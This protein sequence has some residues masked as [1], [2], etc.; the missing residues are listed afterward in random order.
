MF[1]LLL[2]CL[3]IIM[4]AKH[5]E[6]I[7]HISTK[8]IATIKIINRAGDTCKSFKDEVIN[9]EIICIL[10]GLKNIMKTQ[11]NKII[12]VVNVT[13]ILEINFE[14]SNWFFETGKVCVR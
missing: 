7:A 8:N 10:S 14:S 1:F 3:P 4:P 13:T 12:I 5:I 2:N 11:H 9:V 6:M